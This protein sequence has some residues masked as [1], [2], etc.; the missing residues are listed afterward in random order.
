MA[1]IIKRTKTTT[2]TT[3]ETEVL[4]L[5]SLTVREIMNIPA[6]QDDPEAQLIN[7]IRAFAEERDITEEEATKDY[8]HDRRLFG[9]IQLPTKS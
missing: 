7:Q 5:W 6:D 4:S 8:L 9:T 3:V 1:I 2:T